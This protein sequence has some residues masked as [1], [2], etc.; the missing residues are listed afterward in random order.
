VVSVCGKVEEALFLGVPWL[1]PYLPP[2]EVAESL[3][4][5]PPRR[6]WDVEVELQAADTGPLLAVVS[7]LLEDSFQPKPIWVNQK[8]R[9]VVF[10]ITFSYSRGPVTLAPMTNTGLKELIDGLPVWTVECKMGPKPWS[11][12]VFPTFEYA[13]NLMFS[14]KTVSCDSP[15]GVIEDK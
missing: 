12:R 8:S 11:V 3:A 14:V 15:L 9:I 1:V 5:S 2:L 10:P 6:N 13:H 7:L 4:A